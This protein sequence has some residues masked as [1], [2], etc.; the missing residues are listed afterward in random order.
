MNNWGG[1]TKKWQ[2]PVYLPVFNYILGDIMGGE[3][4]YWLQSNREEK[5]KIKPMVFRS[6]TK[7]H[8]CLKTM[9]DE[10]TSTSTMTGLHIAP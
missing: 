9:T 1:D 5:K 7:R 6:V 2:T 10:K 8:I 4:E 3:Q